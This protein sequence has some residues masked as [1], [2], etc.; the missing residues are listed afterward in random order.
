MTMGAYNA[1]K[2][3]DLEIAMVLARELGST[4]RKPSLTAV[5]LQAAFGARQLDGTTRERID[6]A[7]EAVGLHTQPSILDAHPDEALVFRNGDANGRRF[8]RAEPA[9]GVGGPAAAS[10]PVGAIVAGT[11]VP[12]L[13]TALAGWRF[14]LSFAAFAVVA[15]GFLFSRSDP[16]AL[17][18]DGR[19]FL[20]AIAG[21][22]LLSILGAVALAGA[23]SSK[24]HTA[25]RTTP[26][27]PAPRPV[28]VPQ[29]TTPTATTPAPKSHR[30]TRRQRA[31]KPPAPAT[32][33]TTPS[34][35]PSTTP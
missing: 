31:P 22:C 12:V 16:A 10:P 33:N 8:D 24:T 19:T 7:L 5:Q 27:K 6:A 9:E 35:T 32:P 11:V 14:G 29:R 4:E 25:T 26:A 30:R 20:T 3:G 2:V 21:L 15:A 1:V 34:T 23:S 28:I 18:R 13:L 17:L